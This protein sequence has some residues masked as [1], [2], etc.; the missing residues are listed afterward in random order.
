MNPLTEWT[1]TDSKGITRLTIFLETL[2]QM[3][4]L[5][6]APFAAKADRLNKIKLRPKSV[7]DLIIRQQ[8]RPPFYL[9]HE[10]GAY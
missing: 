9:C 3:V 2:T 8:Q 6:A 7:F 10:A 5:K 4:A 1:Q